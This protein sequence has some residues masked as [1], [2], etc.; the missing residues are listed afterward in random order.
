MSFLLVSKS[1]LTQLIIFGY[2]E[3]SQFVAINV[4]VNVKYSMRS[5]ISVGC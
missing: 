2:Y 1:E 4:N 3:N 5:K